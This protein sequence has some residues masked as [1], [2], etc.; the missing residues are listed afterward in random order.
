MIK[1][2]SNL[3]NGGKAWR[4]GRAWLR[5]LRKDIEIEWS[6][7]KRTSGALQLSVNGIEHRVLLNVAVPRL[8]SYWFVVRGANI[9]GDE[10]ELSLRFFDGGAWWILWLNPNEWTCTDGWRR[11]CFHP[12]DFLLGRQ[13][14]SS[15]IVRTGNTDVDILESIY[16]ATYTETMDTWKRPRWPR[17]LTARRFHIDMV[18]P[19]PMPG[20]GENSWDQDDDALYSIVVSCEQL[21][22]AVEYIRDSV[23]KRR[24]RYGGEDWIPNP[25]VR[26]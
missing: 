4:V 22:T 12:V 17:K 6:H 24:L 25:E 3:N 26:N 2:W 16:L 15:Q 7:F 13:R 1:H 21:S 20:K 19:I 14:H 10:R 5:V 9:Y 23:Y 11:G 18:E 8:F